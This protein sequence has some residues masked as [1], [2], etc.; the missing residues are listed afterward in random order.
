MDVFSMS[1]KFSD[2]QIVLDDGSEF[3]ASKFLLASHSVFFVKLFT[4]NNTDKYQVEQVTSQ[5]FR[6]IID[7]M[8]KS[9]ICLDYDVLLDIL[10][11]ADYLDCQHIVE[12]ATKCLK[13]KINPENVVGTLTF[14]RYYSFTE[15]KTW[16][17][18]YIEFYFP[19]V[20]LEEAFLSLPLDDLVGLLASNKLNINTEIQALNAM[21]RWV[22]HQLEERKGHLQTL[23]QLLRHSQLKIELIETCPKKFQNLDNT[24]LTAGSANEV[25]AMVKHWHHQGR[26]LPDLHMDQPL[27]ENPPRLCYNTLLWPERDRQMMQSYNKTSNTWTRLMLKDPVK[28]RESRDILMVGKYVYLIG[29][30]LKNYFGPSLSLARLNVLTNKKRVLS[31]MKERRADGTMVALEDGRILAAG[32]YNETVELYDPVKNE[33]NYIKPMRQKRSYGHGSAVLCGKVYVAGGQA[34]RLLSSMECYDPKTKRWTNLPRMISRRKDFKLVAAEGQL[35]AI[36]GGNNGRKCER[37]NFD[38]RKW[39]S[40]PDMMDPAPYRSC[41]ATVAE[42]KIIVSDPIRGS[43]NSFDLQSQT[44]SN[45]SEFELYAHGVFTTFGE[46]LIFGPSSNINHPDVH[47]PQ[48]ENLPEQAEIMDHTHA[49]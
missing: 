5:S 38:Q 47:A 25:W 35:Y 39:F 6:H 10:Q 4:H 37:F 34:K 18:N 29:G 44:W 13:M 32:G 45:F 40:I 1:K 33:W 27:P 49:N 31:P 15:L 17:L 41:G 7:W 14:C 46:S 8:Y 23:F 11:V 12:V 24:H 28:D 30:H 43:L 2:V 9:Q 16:C 48:L 36:G 21:I 20:C 22:H 42:G 19:T 3:Y 26:H